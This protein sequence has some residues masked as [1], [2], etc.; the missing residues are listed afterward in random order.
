MFLLSRTQGDGADW[1]LQ[2][3]ACPLV[4]W[5]VRKQEPFRETEKAVKHN[6]FEILKH[7]SKIEFDL[8]MIAFYDQ[9]QVIQGADEFVS[10]FKQIYH[11]YI[12]HYI[13]CSPMEPL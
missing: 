9:P 11:Y 8:F 1:V 2:G 7:Y 3:R 6:G 10:S 12:N 13:T 4:L 5:D